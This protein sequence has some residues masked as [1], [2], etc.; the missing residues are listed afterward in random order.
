[1]TQTPPR[2]PDCGVETEPMRF[3]ASGYKMRFV[4]EE[5]TDGILGELGVKQKFGAE[6]FVCPECGLARLYADLHE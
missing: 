5:S 1:M 4:S 2:C 3:D 6:A